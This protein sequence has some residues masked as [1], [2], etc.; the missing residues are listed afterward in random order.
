[1]KKIRTLFVLM[2]AVAM[3]LVGMSIPAVAEE[4]PVVIRF[5]TWEGE[6]MNAAMLA[7]YDKFMEEN[8]GIKVELEPS[9]LTDYGIKLQE[10]LAADIAPDIFMVGNDMALS[11]DAN[12]L[13]LDLTPYMEADSEFADG[14]YSGVMTTYTQDGKLVGLPGLVNMYGVFY[15][16]DMF[17][18][19]GLDYPSEDWTFDDMLNAAEALK[20]E[21]Q[22]RYG[23]YHKTNDVFKTSI[24]SASKDGTGFCDAIFPVTQVQ[25]SDSFKEGISLISAA[26][27]SN[28]ITPPSYDETNLVANFMQGAVPM[29]CYGQWAADEIIR[30]APETLNWGYAPYPKVEK[31]AQIID[32]VGWCIN[33]KTENPDAAFA[34]LKYLESETYKEVLG[35]TPV[36]PPAFEAAAE[37]YYNFLRSSGSGDVADSLEYMLKAEIKLPVRFLDTWSSKASK[38]LDA[39][40]QGIITG[41]SPIDAV[42]TLVE[43]INDVINK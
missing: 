27:Q 34:V 5:M 22:Q 41:S 11:Y 2:L 7:T 28:A 40:W 3:L 10:M 15:N 32:A 31:N 35:Q 43:N 36:A 42:D 1:M 25:A 16:K 38:F 29:M 4:D 18:E 9:P 23:L 39:D 6:V 19:A 21:S 26:I 37:N 13:V 33:A 20:D 24:Y 17:D 30:N 12:G 8:P 14:F